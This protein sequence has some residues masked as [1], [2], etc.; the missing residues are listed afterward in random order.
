MITGV[1]VVFITIISNVTILVTF[2]IVIR[3][4][5]VGLQ[6]TLCL[7]LALRSEARL[8]FSHLIEFGVVCFV[9]IVLEDFILLVLH[10]LIL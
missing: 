2:L 7:V 6:A 9:S 8:G 5:I 10:V 4:F 3:L 1:V